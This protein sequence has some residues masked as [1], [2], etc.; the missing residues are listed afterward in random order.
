MTRSLVRE[1]QCVCAHVCTEPEMVDLTFGGQSTHLQGRTHSGSACDQPLARLIRYIPGT[2]GHG[3]YVRVGNHADCF[4]T[5]LSRETCK[6]PSQRQVGFSACFVIG[7]TCQFHGCARNKQR[8]LTGAPRQNWSPSMQGCGWKRLQ[9]FFRSLLSISSHI[10]PLTEQLHA[11][12]VLGGSF[13]KTTRRTSKRSSKA[14]AQTCVMFLQSIC[15]F[16]ILG[17]QQVHSQRQEH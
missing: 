1:V 11:S 4:M 3:R 17:S 5:H 7:L 10:H 12:H 9:L 15:F 2:V 8:Y 14:G 6:I 13:V 16:C